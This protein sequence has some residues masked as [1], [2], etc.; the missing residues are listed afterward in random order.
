MLWKVVPASRELPTKPG[1]NQAALKWTDQQMKLQQIKYIATSR[2]LRTSD[3]SSF[4][5]RSTE[6]SM[7]VHVEFMMGLNEDYFHKYNSQIHR[8]EVVQN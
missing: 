1:K 5:L 7:L 3:M 8:C 6:R 4:S 2:S